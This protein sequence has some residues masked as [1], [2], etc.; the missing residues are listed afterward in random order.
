[1]Y[2]LNSFHRYILVY[3]HIYIYI[4]SIITIKHFIIFNR[5]MS[6]QKSREGLKN[7]FALGEV[8]GFKT[9]FLVKKLLRVNFSLVTEILLSVE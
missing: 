5:R 6:F 8:N 2:C 3:I 1:M 9:V 7:F 4:H